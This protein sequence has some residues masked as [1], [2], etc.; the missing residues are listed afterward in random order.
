MNSLGEMNGTDGANETAGMADYRNEAIWP[1]NEA[2]WPRNAAVNS[3]NETVG[4]GN[5]AVNFRNEAVKRTSAPWRTEKRSMRKTKRSMTGRMVLPGIG[6]FAQIQLSKF[7]PKKK[8]GWKVG[9][10]E[11]WLI[12]SCNGGNM[13]T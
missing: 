7:P 9:F 3:Q 2:I 10:R 6:G 1:K 5:E 12:S 4:L 13:Y 8:V 11:N